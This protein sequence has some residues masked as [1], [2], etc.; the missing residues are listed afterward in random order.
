MQMQMSRLTLKLHHG[1]AVLLLGA[2]CGCTSTAPTRPDPVADA[3]PVRFKAEAPSPQENPPA[4][5]RAQWWTV[6]DDPVLD[7]LVERANQGN[8]DIQIAA[9]RLAYAKAIAAQA[10]SARQP[11]AGLSAGASRLEGPLLNAAGQEGT[12]L[13]AG[14][15]LSYEVDVLGRLSKAGEA[16]ALDQQSRAALLNSARLIT[17]TQ[18]AQTYLALRFLDEETHVLRQSLA[19]DHQALQIQAARLQS[20]SISEIDFEHQRSE[21]TAAGAQPLVLQQRRT[22]LENTL[23]VLLGEAP[24]EFQLEPAAWRATLPML[25]PGVPAQVL[26]RR[27]D[28]SAAQSNVLAAQQRL[29]IARTAWFPGLT[30]TGGSGFASTD[31]STLFSVSVQTWALGALATVPL[32]DGGRRE[33]S[34]AMADADLQAAAVS[35]RSQVLLALR[36][37]EDQISATRSL[38]LQSDVMQRAWSSAARARDLSDTRLQS[39]SIS[40]LDWLNARR[41]ELHT[42]RQVVLARAAQYQASVALLRAMGGGWN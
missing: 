36:E 14:A 37:V 26:A 23:A 32:L 22:E 19:A 28:I 40:R 5:A 15:T 3:P 25:Q 1:A 31:L 34:V 9:S 33:A 18:V 27:P 35:Y 29:G 41:S 21:S 24:S 4:V 16:A 12:L 10:G 30:L 7:G 42:R 39:G 8:T 20:G 2:L 17:Q 11:Q 6:F 13:T 38:A